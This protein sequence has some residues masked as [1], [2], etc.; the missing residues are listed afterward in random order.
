MVPVAA[1][2]VDH[3][4]MPLL[5]ISPA[6][7]PETSICHAILVAHRRMDSLS[8]ALGP[9]V[10]VSSAVGS[11]AFPP[12]APSKARMNVDAAGMIALLHV[13]LVHALLGV[14]LQELTCWTK[15]MTSRFALR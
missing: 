6:A 12:I 10:K 7:R 13:M 3:L 1:V 15:T 2:E 11:S 9:T 5:W 4:P 14:E 8:A